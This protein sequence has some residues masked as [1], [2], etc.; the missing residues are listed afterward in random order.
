MLADFLETLSQQLPEHASLER[1]SRRIGSHSR[2]SIYSDSCST[3]RCSLAYTG[4]SLTHNRLHRCCPLGG[5]PCR[6][7]RQHSSRQSESTQ[8]RWVFQAPQG[9]AR[10]HRHARH[11]QTCTTIDPVF[12][13]HRQIIH[14]IDRGSVGRRPDEE[15]RKVWRFKRPW[16]CAADAATTFVLTLVRLGWSARSARHL[17]IRSGTTMDLLGVAPSGPDR[18]ICGR[19]P[20]KL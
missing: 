8:P 9:T 18:F 13:R 5:P 16:S 20:G 19:S 4:L 6:V 3:P 11:S 15:P 2:F 1:C 12:W 14:R 7:S 17:V 10:H